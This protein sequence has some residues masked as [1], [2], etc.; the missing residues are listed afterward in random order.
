MKN[1]LLVLMVV[2]GVILPYGYPYSFLIQYILM[3]ILV[4]AFLDVKIDKESIH[5][6]HFIILVINIIFPIGLFYLLKPLNLTLA[7]TVLITAISPTAI[8]ST[9]ITSLLKRKVEYVIVSLLLTNSVIALLIPFLI[10]A[11]L[12]GNGDISVMDLL[13]PVLTVFLIPFVIAQ[14]LKYTLPKVH[15][16]LLKHRNYSFYLLAIS[17]YIATSKASHYIQSEL[18]ASI[19]IVVYIGL[20]TF[21]IC[22]VYFI[23]GYFVGGKKYGLEA[24]QS[25]GQKNNAFTIWLSLTFLNP[26]IALGPTFYVLAHNLVI[27]GQL[28]WMKKKES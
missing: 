12:G 13:I 2:L 3:T 14:L 23:I 20:A 11:L 17:V 1:I 26:I 7:T 22:A 21:L 18:D 5:K 16:F 28:Y 27:S 4:L 25:L 6:T 10:P 8:S 19:D 9:V 24:A 15:G